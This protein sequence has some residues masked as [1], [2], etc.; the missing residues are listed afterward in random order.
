MSQLQL[1]LKK[2]NFAKI[3]K[4][5]LRILVSSSITGDAVPITIVLDDET[6]RSF[7]IKIKIRAWPQHC[8]RTKRVCERDSDE[9]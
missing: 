3:T 6:K 8:V 7:T 5:L 4:I 2:G 9:C 1:A